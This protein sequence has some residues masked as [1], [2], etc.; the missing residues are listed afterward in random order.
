[1]FQTHPRHVKKHCF[2]TDKTQIV[3]IVLL[4]NTEDE[5]NLADHKQVMEIRE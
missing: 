5:D 4:A 2:V 1:M 3:G